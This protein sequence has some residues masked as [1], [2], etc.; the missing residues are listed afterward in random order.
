MF[1]GLSTIIKGNPRTQGRCEHL[2]EVSVIIPAYNHADLL[3]R[4]I[5]SVLD[6]TFRDFELL[7]VDDG[8]TDNT[9]EVVEGFSRIDSRVAYVWQKNSG[10]PAGPR[11]TGIE[12]SKGKYVAFLDHDDE[13]MKTKLEKQVRLFEESPV[14]TGFV[15]CDYYVMA[16]L[17]GE[18]KSEY[19]LPAFAGG[20][21]F[22]SIL[23]RDF[24]KTASVVVVRKNVLDDVGGFDEQLK[25]GED[26]DLWLR[27]SEK[28]GFATV[29]EFLAIYYAYRG[30]T[31]LRTRAIDL[32]ESTEC[33]LKK[34]GR[35]FEKHPDAYSFRLGQVAANYCSAGELGK[36]RKYYIQSI[37]IDKFNF[38]SYLSLIT[39]YVLGKKAFYVVHRSKGWLRHVFRFK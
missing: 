12:K 34:H 5:K 35:S 6:Q 15:A 17:K 2:P 24:I 10:G 29:R 31:T 37:M 18:T 25:C 39:S 1:T 32:A 36:G 26:T 28:Y 23:R 14:E 30:N 19:R 11:N 33:I 27:I 8:S 7:V 21:A 22:G 4:T 9:D 16:G 38:K 13:W 3:P 20:T